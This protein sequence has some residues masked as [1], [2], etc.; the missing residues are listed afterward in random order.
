MVPSTH[1]HW[2]AQLLRLSF[3]HFGD[4]FAVFCM[5][6]VLGGS[7]IFETSYNN[8]LLQWPPTPTGIYCDSSAFHFGQNGSLDLQH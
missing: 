7:E 2:M 4:C 3:A 1:K 5:S 8:S 6:K